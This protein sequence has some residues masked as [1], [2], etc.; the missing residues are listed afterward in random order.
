LAELKPVFKQRWTACEYLEYDSKTKTAGCRIYNGNR[1]KI[2]RKFS[3]VNC[4]DR[5]K[6]DLREMRGNIERYFGEQ[7]KVI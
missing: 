3:C 6:E 4:D 2:C 7:A 5:T 1:S